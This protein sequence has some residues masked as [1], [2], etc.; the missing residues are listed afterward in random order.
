MPQEENLHQ[1]FLNL[2]TKELILN[3]KKRIKYLEEQRIE[4]EK[5]KKA[6]EVEKLKKRFAEYEQKP[7]QVEIQTKPQI[8]KKEERIIPEPKIVRPL[9]NTQVIEKPIVHEVIISQPPI[10]Q[11]PQFQTPQKQLFQKQ[12]EKKHEMPITKIALQPVQPGE[13]DYGKISFLIN[14]HLVTS[15]ECP[16]ENKNI[17]IRRAGST[18]KTQI[19]LNKAEI[20]E[21]IKSFSEKAKIPLIE[22]MLNARIADLEIAAIVSETMSPSFIIKRNMIQ[23][24][25]TGP[26]VLERPMM[27]FPRPGIQ[28]RP[29][30]PMPPINRPFTTPAT[31]AA[32]PKNP[33]AQT[34]SMEKSMVPTNE[35]APKEI[36]PL[37][38]KPETLPSNNPQPKDDNFLSKSLDEK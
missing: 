37:T 24:N 19:T 29:A 18:I 2:F 10:Q 20:L 8:I 38:V 13:V 14:D 11:R 31:P 25:P 27:Q 32:A 21:T 3:L 1:I 30:S 22:G 23:V 16:G 28:P 17:I 15:I 35:P 9:Q 4:E 34:P 5:A 6:V 33:Q 26:S 36:E 12:V 7:I